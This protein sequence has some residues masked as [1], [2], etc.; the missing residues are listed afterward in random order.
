[1]TKLDVLAYLSR[2]DF[3]HRSYQ[4]VLVKGTYFA[5]A[6]AH[7][8]MRINSCLRAFAKPAVGLRRLC[9]SADMNPAGN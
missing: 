2:L 6:N 1:M 4:C 3:G 5:L 9:D 7:D 8:N